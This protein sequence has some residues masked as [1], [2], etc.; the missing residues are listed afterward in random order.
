[1][2]WLLR[3]IVFL[4]LLLTF[5]GGASTTFAQ[6]I[7][8]LGPIN[9]ENVYALGAGDRLV[10]NTNYCVRP[11]D[12]KTK[13]KIGSVLQISV[14]RVISLHPDLVLA[15]ALTRPEQIRQLQD[16]GIEVVRFKRTASFAE[17]CAEFLRLGRLLGLEGEAEEIIARAESMV[18]EVRRK[19]AGSPTPKVFIQVG[20]MPLF[21]AVPNS[22]THDFI[23]LAGGI[24]IIAD[25]KT[26]TTSLEKVIGAN[27]EVIIIGIMGS[28]SGIAAHEKRKWLQIPVIAAVENGRVHIINP[29][30]ICS[31]SPL[32][33]AR[34]LK[35]VAGMIHPDGFKD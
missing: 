3:I 17:I 35:L 5:A 30:L 4:G 34:T 26:G 32:T 11:E 8:S 20:A 1:M 18:A 31:P 14:E 13:A 21:G 33:F 16:V 23:V 24:N 10:G 27:P 9:T 29:D 2:F 28:E 22:F 6:R 19:V 15:T 12:A 25:Q 7:V